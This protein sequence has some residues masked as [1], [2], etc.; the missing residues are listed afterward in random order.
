MTTTAAT[1]LNTLVEPARRKVV[2]VVA[3]VFVV[4]HVMV[5][6]WGFLMIKKGMTLLE[7]VV[8]EC[9]IH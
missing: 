9:V 8:V 4:R 1:V 2:L 6:R 5:H 7:V 3:A